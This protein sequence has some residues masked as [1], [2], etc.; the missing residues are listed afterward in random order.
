MCVLVIFRYIILN[1]FVVIL[2]TPYQSIGHEC[3][4]YNHMALMATSLP[5]GQQ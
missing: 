2:G 3:E 4:W 5:V 1:A